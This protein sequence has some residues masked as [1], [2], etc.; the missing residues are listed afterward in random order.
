M[1]KK[2]I[3]GF[4]KAIEAKDLQKVKKYISMDKAFVN[5]HN[6]STPKV[7]A[8]QTGLQVAIKKSS[9]E[10]AL[11]LIEQ[12]ADVNFIEDKKFNNEPMPVLHFC[13]G[14]LFIYC[15]HEYY[16]Q[17]KPYYDQIIKILKIMLLKGANPRAVYWCGNNS[18][19]CAIMGIHNSTKNPNFK[20]IEKIAI[21]RFR[22]ILKTL[23]D[24]GADINEKNNIGENSIDLIKKFGM[25]G[26][27]LI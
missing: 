17:C 10:I 27:K 2:D 15:L 26:Y 13:I 14:M 20:E 12:G 21:V 6:G 23:I 25:E 9:F 18:L 8:G 3:L 24:A 19:H 22:E 5:S 1:T 11:F 16:K 4:M 7:N